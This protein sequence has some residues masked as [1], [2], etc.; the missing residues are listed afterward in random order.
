MSS[1]LGF[2][3]TY[4]FLFTQIQTFNGIYRIKRRYEHA[5]QAKDPK[6]PIVITD[7]SVK[8]QILTRAKSAIR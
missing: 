4:V 7:H 2:Y 3:C 1:E 8:I 5:K 6:T